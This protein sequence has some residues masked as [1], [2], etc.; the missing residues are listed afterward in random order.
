M[1]A[2]VAIDQA[3][4]ATAPSGYFTV[5]AAMP[6]RGPETACPS[7]PNKRLQ[8][9]LNAIVAHYRPYGHYYHGGVRR[10]EMR[11]TPLDRHY[12]ALEPE[13]AP[14]AHELLTMT[15]ELREALRAAGWSDKK[16]DAGLKG[17]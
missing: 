11:A 2:I 8:P 14:T 9:A 7:L 13:Q 17:H 3:L 12:H 16:I 4:H 5:Y 6:P 15:E 10:S 1:N